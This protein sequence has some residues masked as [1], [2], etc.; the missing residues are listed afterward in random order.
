VCENHGLLL[1]LEFQ[2]LEGERRQAAAGFQ[3]PSAPPIA[4]HV[5]EHPQKAVS[6]GF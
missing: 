4:L 1:L 6:L 3:V 5:H 2:D